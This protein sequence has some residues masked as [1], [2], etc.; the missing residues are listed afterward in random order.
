[1]LL[2]LFGI[3]SAQ[4]VQLEYWSFSFNSS[5]TYTGF[6]N[7]L[8]LLDGITTCCEEGQ[9][10]FNVS[11][12]YFPTQFTVYAML[13][14][15][16]Y[17][18]GAIPSLTFYEGHYVLTASYD[19]FDNK[20]TCFDPS[21][22]NCEY[23]QWCDFPCSTFNVSMFVANATHSNSK[24]LVFTSR[25]LELSSLPSQVSNGIA[26]W[27]MYVDADLYYNAFS[28]SLATALT[29][30]VPMCDFGDYCLN[31][32]NGQGVPTDFQ[33]FAVFDNGT[34][35]F[36]DTYDLS[37]RLS[38]TR[39]KLTVQLTSNYTTSPC[40]LQSGGSGN[41]CEYGNACTALCHNNVTVGFTLAQPNV[42]KKSRG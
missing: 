1:V 32:T 17:V 23:N 34:T 14:Q 28:N 22:V 21:S 16:E 8:G 27:G 19:F 6:A 25:S 20:Y 36:Y 39:Y 35:M 37:I 30:S 5:N 11:K 31:V 29:C 3:L 40:P 2:V 38:S 26:Y 24:E 9:Y 42:D 41:L 7:D 15:S 4:S 18:L 13:T 10:C 33:V 12:D